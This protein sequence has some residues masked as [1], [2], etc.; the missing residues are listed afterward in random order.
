M[1]GEGRSRCKGKIPIPAGDQEV[2]GIMGVLVNCEESTA[3]ELFASSPHGF[4]GGCGKQVARGDLE[5]DAP[6]P[7]HPGCEEHSG[8]W[9]SGQERP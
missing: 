9:V 6:S 4:P 1:S 3:D 8:S 2:R 7:L 5:A